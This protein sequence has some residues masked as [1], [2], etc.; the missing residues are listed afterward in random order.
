MDLV[1]MQQLLDMMLVMER[2]S[3][4]S[5]D[6]GLQRSLVLQGPAMWIISECGYLV[7]LD[8]V[9]NGPST[10]LHTVYVHNMKIPCIHFHSIP[11]ISNKV[12]VNYS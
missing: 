12:M 6:R 7:L 8:K 2:T 3:S 10:A 1:G 9:C 5:R 11:I 4:L